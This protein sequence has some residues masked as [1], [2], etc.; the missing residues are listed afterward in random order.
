[1][2]KLTVWSLTI[3]GDEVSTSVRRTEQELMDELR[4]QWAVDKDVPD[5]D[6]VAAVIKEYDVVIHGPDEH[7]LSDPEPTARDA[8]IEDVRKNGKCGD[9]M[10]ACRT[11]NLEA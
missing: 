3:E 9:A 10:C 5:E 4:E 1:M 8:W 2:S 6:L 11:L 7:D